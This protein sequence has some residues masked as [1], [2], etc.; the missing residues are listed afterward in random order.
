MVGLGQEG[1]ALA[2]YLAQHDVSVTATDLKT[3]AQFESDLPGLE[4]AGVTLILGENPAWLLDKID[5]VFVS[6][7]V[8][9]T[10]SLV[11]AAQQ[12]RLPLSTES[13]LFCQL[14]PAPIVALTGSSGKTTTTTLVGEIMNASG[15]KTWVGGNIGQ[16]LISL[17]D[18]IQPSDVVVMELSSFQLEYFHNQVVSGPL[19]SLQKGWSP[20]IAAILNITPNHLDRHSSM[21]DYIRAKRAIVDYQTS[22]GVMILNDDDEITRSIGEENGDNVRWFSLYGAHPNGATLAGDE[23]V[24]LD[25]ERWPHPVITRQEV[26]L[27]GDHNISNILAACLL[28]R[29]AGA[30]IQAMHQVI[31]NFGGVEHR[32]EWVRTLNHVDYFNDSIATTP[33]RMKAALR[34]FAQPI[35]LLAGGYDKHLPWD[36]AAKLIHQKAV[37]VV[38][39]GEAAGL[40][41]VAL[42]QVKTKARAK[43]HHAESMDAAV[44]IATKLSQPGY[45]VLLSPGCASYDA[46]ANY[47]TRGER[48]KTLVRAL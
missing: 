12:Q 1:T 44:E 41:D 4:A 48:F 14:C 18:D 35:I 37:H 38:L 16:P 15:F 11:V 23:L 31:S 2:T 34:A 36:T 7:G 5:I 46:F 28:S 40:I 22:T 33:D 43:I 17:V 21:A 19:A 47:A 29:E 27:R 6:P 8:P 26:K 3:A 20:P 32:I 9:L 39:F 30:S 10:S 25:E 42:E 13:R 45:V 24:L